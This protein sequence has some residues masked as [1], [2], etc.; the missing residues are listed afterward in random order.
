MD[1]SIMNGFNIYDVLEAATSTVIVRYVRRIWR[2]FKAL[3]RKKSDD[4]PK[5]KDPV[6]KHLIE[7]FQDRSVTDTEYMVLLSYARLK[8]E[9]NLNRW[10]IFILFL[11]LILGDTIYSLISR[12]I[13]HLINL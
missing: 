6:F 1:E 12:L 9:I 10:V 4:S 5:I 3:F 7:R 11:L 2:R 8:S 13:E